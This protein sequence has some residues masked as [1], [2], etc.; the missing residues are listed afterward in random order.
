MRTNSRTI[1]FASLLSGVMTVF[2]FAGCGDDGR[3]G[4]DDPMMC[5]TGQIQCG[6]RCTNINADFNNCGSCGNSCLTGQ[7]CTSGVCVGDPRVDTGPQPDTGPRPDS[8]PGG[9]CS[10]TCSSTQQ[11]CGTTCVNRMSSGG[12]GRADSSFQHC[13]RCNN[14][15]DM[16]R[17]SSCGV[18]GGT[19]QCLCGNFP[20]CGSG[21][22]CVPNGAGFI[23]ANLQF[24]PM[25]CGTVGNA[26]GEGETCNAGVCGCG[27]AGPCSTGQACCAGA[28]T[29]TATSATNCG[30]CGVTCGMGTTCMGGGCICPGSGAACAAPSGT[31]LGELCCATGCV[32]Q[33]ATNC[34]GCGMAC[35]GSDMCVMG[36]GFGGGATQICCSPLPAIPGF[37]SIC[38]PSI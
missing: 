13:G 37:P 23:C 33:N 30:G 2:L 10:P 27:S 18:S 20:Q 16:D 35:D 4:D 12:D 32:P 25:N 1:P 5:V 29:N 31:S 9:M 24:D 6:A 21:Q 19:V 34:G 28:C 22:A 26:C 14:A 38:P 36:M 3:G 8:G 7:S 17:A 15:C 11:C